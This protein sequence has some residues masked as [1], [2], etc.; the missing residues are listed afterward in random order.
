MQLIRFTVYSLKTGTKQRYRKSTTGSE[1]QLAE[2]QII[3]RVRLDATDLQVSPVGIGTWAWGDRLVWGYG[4]GGYTDDDLKAAFQ[5]TLD[6]GINF[7]DTAELYGFPTHRSEKLLGKFK[8][9]SSNTV[10]ATKF[11]PLPW[12]FMKRQ[13]IAALKGSIKRLG[14]QQVD[15]Y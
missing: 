12:R 5:V 2:Q 14:V 15:L 13:L 7:F 4:G 8:Q 1:A 11:F 9:Q 6:A 10:I 3:E